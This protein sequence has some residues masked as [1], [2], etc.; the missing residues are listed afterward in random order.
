[1]LGVTLSDL[2]DHLDGKWLELSIGGQDSALMD[3]PL[4]LC[5]VKEAYY[6]LKWN[7]NGCFSQEISNK[8]EN[9]N[10]NPRFIPRQKASF[11]EDPE[12]ICSFHSWYSYSIDTWA[13]FYDLERY[14]MERAQANFW[15]E[16]GE[17]RKT[18]LGLGRRGFNGVSFAQDFLAYSIRDI[19]IGASDSLRQLLDYGYFFQ[20]RATTDPEVNNYE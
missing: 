20:G 7:L 6:I 9:G 10:W 2:K 15:W 5:S 13:S 19:A 11:A 3:S 4:K 14:G 8:I 17:I 16:T 12:N 1:M 18:F